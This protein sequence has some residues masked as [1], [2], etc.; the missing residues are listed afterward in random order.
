MQG[1]AKRLGSLNAKIDAAILDTGDGRLRNAAQ[2][3][4]LGLAQALQLTDDA[5]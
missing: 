5:H 2:G 1:N 4:K 3:R